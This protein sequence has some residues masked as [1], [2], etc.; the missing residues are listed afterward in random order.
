MGLVMGDWDVLNR[1]IELGFENKV[2]ERNLA[3][4]GVVSLMHVAVVG[5]GRIG[6]SLDM[7][8]A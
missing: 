8:G 3:A 1:S 2:V 5:L 7:V 6:L 4:S